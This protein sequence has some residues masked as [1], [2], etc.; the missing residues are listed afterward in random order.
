MWESIK[1]CVYVSFYSLIAQLVKNPPQCQKPQFNSWV[2]KIPWRR[3]RLPT[4]V[5]L[6]FTCGSA[7]K[8]S[9]GN[10]GDLGSIPGFWKILWRMERLPTPVFWP[11]EFHGLDSPW[12]RK[13]LDMTERL[14]L[15]T[16]TIFYIYT[17][18]IYWYTIWRRAW[19]LTREFH[20][21]RSLADYNPWVA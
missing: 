1:Y 3:A 18:Y 5:F 20:E 4:P 7:G 9:A 8:E 16:D 10:A 21:Q 13:E 6:G 12:G 2:G 14:T 11:G 15:H 17:F 19:Q